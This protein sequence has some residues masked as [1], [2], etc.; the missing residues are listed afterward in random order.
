MK[1]CLKMATGIMALTVVSMSLEAAVFANI[2]NNE[3]LQI[4]SQVREKAHEI[5]ELAVNAAASVSQSQSVAI[6]IP[7]AS[8]SE[9]FLEQVRLDS[10]QQAAGAAYNLSIIAANRNDLTLASSLIKEAIQ[11]NYSNPNYLSIAA[12]IAF[13]T[14][15]YDKAEEYQLMVLEIFR[16]ALEPDDLQVAVILDQLSAIYVVQER[17]EET[18]SCLQESLQLREKVLGNNHLLLTVSLN[19]LASL[20]VRQERPTAAESLLKRSLD[21][22]RVASGPRHANIATMLANLADLYHG[23]ARLE[24]A[25]P[26]YKEAISIWLESPGDS[27]RLA[28]SQNSLGQLFL[29]QRRFDDARLQFEQVLFLLKQNYM[30]DHPYVQ[31]VIR[32][33]T[34]LDAERARNVM[35]ENM[36]DEL[37]RQLGFQLPQHKELTV[38]I[39]S[40]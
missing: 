7:S 1:N 5:D 29:S 17:Y 38:N 25:E 16:S 27:L 35:E 24:E 13:I 8:T 33:L 36:Y 18:R 19:K 3:R 26:L 10:R 32:N 37:V 4:R 21:I 22:A 28:I 9:E 34:D 31:Q 12:E 23:E 6:E 20:A 14:Q 2:S 40:P 11:L 15:E 30:Q 39:T